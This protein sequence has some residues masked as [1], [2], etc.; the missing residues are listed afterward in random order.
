MISAAEAGAIIMGSVR[1]LGTITVSLDR[2][3]GKALGE[4]VISPENVP[5][6][7]NAGMDG[8]AVR[9][10]DTSAIPATLTLI[11]EIQAGS[12][13]AGNLRTG[14]T[15]S[16]MTGAA[17]PSGADAVVQLEWTGGSA[18]LRWKSSAASG[19][20]TISDGQDRTFKPAPSSWR[21]GVCCV[22]RRSASWRLSEGVS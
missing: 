3:L 19:R 20:D 1:P 10:A 8:Y 11:G 21:K 12:L 13:P 7:D 15:L 4:D 5:S 22:H 17:I 16:I 14:E 2:C 9:S 18:T 6:F